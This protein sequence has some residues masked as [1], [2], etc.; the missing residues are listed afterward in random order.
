MSPRNPGR[1]RIAHVFHGSV[2]MKSCNVCAS[3]KQLDEFHKNK[4]R[5]DG[6]MPQCKSCVKVKNR[7]N[8]R[9]TSE[10]NK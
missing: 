5:W 10:T 1:P 3:L 6:L 7:A 9:Q 2:E 8:V 4:S